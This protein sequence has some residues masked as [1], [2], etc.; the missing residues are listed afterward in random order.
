VAILPENLSSIGSYSF[1]GCTSLEYINI[2]SSLNNIGTKAFN[3][4][5]F[6]DADGSTVLKKT[7]K[8]LRG[9]EYYGNGDGNLVRKYVKTIDSIFIV[10]GLKYEIKSTDPLSASLVGYEG[11]IQSLVIP[12]FV[13]YNGDQIAIVSVGEKAFY[14]CSTL[15]NV[16][17]GYVE[18]VGEKAFYKC[19]NLKKIN[20]GHSLRTI[21]DYAFYG[22][23]S[24]KYF[25]IGKSADD[26]KIIGSHAFGKCTRLSSIAIPE[27]LTSLG[28]KAFSQTFKD[29]NGLTLDLDPE[30][31]KGHKY[32]NIDGMMIRQSGVVVGKEL[33]SNNLVFKVTSSFPSEVQVLGYT[34]QN[35]SLTIPAT[36]KIEN[37]SYSITSIGEDAFKNCE[38]LKS[39]KMNN[40]KTIGSEAF[41][42]CTNLSTVQATSITSIGTK[43]FAGCTNLA[44]LDFGTSLE[45]I[46]KYA[47]YKCRSLQSISLTSIE[48]IG[49][50][51]F[52]K[53][54]SLNKIY[55]GDSLTKIG[56]KSFSDCPSLCFINIP[57]NLKSVGTE[58]FVDY[59]FQNE[60]GTTLT[61]PEEIRGSIYYRSEDSLIA[62][63]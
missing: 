10:D 29:E 6:Y 28:T 38:T 12:E 54:T 9:F 34:G 47:F 53:C 2:P 46:S 18:K 23:K 61:K 5:T 19:N 7:A 43:A 62:I 32:S 63:P 15:T 58:A 59:K 24:L 36:I 57:S 13:N 31:L 41:Y 49:A 35:K 1:N 8:N 52:Y 11:D 51:A 48:T 16:D 42:C 25:T 44:N 17:L 30:S 33:T 37:V 20:A 26:L 4:I 3:G 21:D 56:S 45:K 14:N 22:C 50:Y 60:N 39:I 27:F 40:V 55:L